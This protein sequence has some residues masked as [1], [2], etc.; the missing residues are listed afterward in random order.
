MTELFKIT[1]SDLK[2][3]H[4]RD[5]GNTND[6]QDPSV[7]LKIGNSSYVTKRF[8]SSSLLLHVLS[9]TSRFKRQ[10]DA[11]INASYAES[12][13]VEI[14]PGKINTSTFLE[15]FLVVKLFSFTFSLYLFNDRLKFG[16]YQNREAS[17]K[18]RF[19][20]VVEM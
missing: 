7:T 9:Y 2:A 13:A 20:L 11:G 8:C 4:L 3:K 6:P 15:V 17:S 5:T 10:K 14:D 19:L 12:F 16:I 1:I 18:K